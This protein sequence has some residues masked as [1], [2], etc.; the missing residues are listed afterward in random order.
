MVLAVG[1]GTPCY[2]DNMSLLKKYTVSYYL[3]ASLQTLHN[4][5]VLEKQHRPLIKDLED[6][7]LLEFIAKHLFE[8][9][10]FYEQANYTIQTDGRSTHEIVDEITLSMR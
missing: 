1:G 2:A 7:Q 5:L 3:K 8:R 4:R 9:R 6:H 10:P